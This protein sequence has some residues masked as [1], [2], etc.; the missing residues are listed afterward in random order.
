MTRSIVTGLHGDFKESLSYHRLGLI[1]LI[2]VCLQF[3]Y[4]L[5]LILVPPLRVYVS[6]FGKILNR[7]IIVLVGVYVLNWVITFVSVI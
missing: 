1:T 7:G 6:G 3:L 5:V 4:R 2:Y